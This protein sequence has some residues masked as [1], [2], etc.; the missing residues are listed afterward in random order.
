MTIPEE[1]ENKLG[2]LLMQ[3]CKL[4]RANAHATM[5]QVGLYR[6]QGMLLHLLCEEDGIAHSELAER[7]CVQ[8]ATITNAVKRMEKAGLV[9][10]RRDTADERISRVYLTAKGRATHIAVR[11][12]WQEMDEQI[13]AGLDPTERETLQ[14]LLLR[15]RDNLLE[16]RND[17]ARC[18]S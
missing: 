6:G 2:H 8:P 10:R 4:H 15:V 9:E 11:E 18:C 3:C 12:V 5:E 14:Q 7:A 1:L 13:F 17:G 16:S